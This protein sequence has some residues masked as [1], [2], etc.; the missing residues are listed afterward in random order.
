MRALTLKQPWA[1]LIANGTKQIE[2]R[3]YPVPKT[4]RGHK[5]AIHAGKGF[6]SDWRKLEVFDFCLQNECDAAE[7]AFKREA[8][9]ILCTARIVGQVRLR[10]IPGATPLE[11]L[12]WWGNRIDCTDERK[13][14][15]CADPFWQREHYGWV[16]EDIKPVVSLKIHRGM[17]GFWTVK[18]DL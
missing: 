12:I 18:G 17:L 2:N 1:S 9:R 16:L 7:E 15:I 11:E 3:T 14:E 13:D 5:V 6:D 10:P 4:V 8:G